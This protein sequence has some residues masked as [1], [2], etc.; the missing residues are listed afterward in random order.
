M[1]QM[2]DNDE[3]PAAQPMVNF[4]TAV[5]AAGC[6]A[7]GL[8]SLKEEEGH[9]A[10]RPYPQAKD[11]SPAPQ[12]SGTTLDEDGASCVQEALPCMHRAA[13]TVNRAHPV[14]GGYQGA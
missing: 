5:G 7:E 1:G 10:V 2:S 14:H 11:A 8:Q 4:F 3:A 13:G 12:G 9:G 6:T